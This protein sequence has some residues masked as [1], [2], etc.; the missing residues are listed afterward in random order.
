MGNTSGSQRETTS[1][2]SGKDAT[3]EMLRIL[4]KNHYDVFYCEHKKLHY[5]VDVTGGKKY[6]RVSMNE[7][8][9]GNLYTCYL[10]Q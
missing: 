9:N 4:K 7:D 6:L 10:D 5:I 8:Y 1:Y 3:E 2:E